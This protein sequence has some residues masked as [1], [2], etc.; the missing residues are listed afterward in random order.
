MAARRPRGLS[1]L[2]LRRATVLLLA[3][4]LVASTVVLGS[5]STS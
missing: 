3:A 1:D 5:A 2:A 4:A